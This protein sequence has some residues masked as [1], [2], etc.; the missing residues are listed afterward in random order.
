[1]RASVSRV[2]AASTMVSVELPGAATSSTQTKKANP[3]VAGQWR[4]LLGRA[5]GFHAFTPMRRTIQARMSWRVAKGSS[6]SQTG[7]KS[8]E[9]T[10]S[11]TQP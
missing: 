6:H 2:Y 4:S 11:P 7:R 10:A 5:A 3:M 8:A 1:M 9:M